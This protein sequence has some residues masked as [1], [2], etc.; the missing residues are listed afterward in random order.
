MD[1][2]RML[3]LETAEN[4]ARMMATY[5]RDQALQTMYA[6]WALSAQRMRALLVNE[7]EQRIRHDQAH[8]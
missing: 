2:D 3:A 4:W 8:A 1:N 5:T 7:R 6:Q